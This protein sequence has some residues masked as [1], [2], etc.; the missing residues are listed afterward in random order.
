MNNLYRALLR[1][2]AVLAA[3][4]CFASQAN[5]ADWS[6][7]YL[8]PTLSRQKANADY[9]TTG[10]SIAGPGLIAPPVWILS[11]ADEKPGLSGT[12]YGLVGGKNWQ[13]AERVVGGLEASYGTGKNG[14]TIYG[15]PGWFRSPSETFTLETKDSYSLAARLGYAVVPDVLVFGTVGQTWQKF[16]GRFQCPGVPAGAWCLSPRDNSKSWSQ[17]GWEFGAGVEWRVLNALSLRADYRTARFNTATANW[18]AG[19]IDEIQSQ[20]RF[21]AQ[22]LGV[23]ATYNF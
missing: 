1:L 5:A 19:S 11:N 21:K 20:I 14:A 7:W 12:R 8:G 2:P 23:G 16:A 17:N 10:L 15:V 6:T 22:S 3:A 18:N 4:G 13:L 9:L